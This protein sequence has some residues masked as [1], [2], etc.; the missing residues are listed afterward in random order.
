VRL[1][2]LAVIELNLHVDDV[3][4]AAARHLRHVLFIPNTAAHGNAVGN[5]GHVHAVLV[6]KSCARSGR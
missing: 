2:Q 5:P 4:D 3:G 1:G 6:P